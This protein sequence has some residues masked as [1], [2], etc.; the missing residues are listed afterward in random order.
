M[1][2]NSNGSS[3][4]GIMQINSSW[5]KPMGLDYQE[6]IKNPCYNV[7]TGAKILK[8]CVDKH[9]YTWEAIGCYNAVSPHVRVKYSWKVF[10]ELSRGHA[11]NNSTA[12][13]NSSSLPFYSSG[14]QWRRSID[15][16]PSRRFTV[17]S[18]NER[19]KKRCSPRLAKGR[20][21]WNL[22]KKIPVGRSSFFQYWYVL[23]FSLGLQ[24][25][26]SWRPLKLRYHTT[27][28]TKTH[29]RQPIP[30]DSTRTEVP[31][32]PSK[33]D[34]HV[35]ATTLAPKPLL[36]EQI[37]QEKPKSTRESSLKMASGVAR[38]GEPGIPTTI[39]TQAQSAG[40]GSTSE[41]LSFEKAQRKNKQRCLSLRS[42]NSRRKRR[43]QTGP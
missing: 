16:E 17:K 7:M 23:F 13:S 39:R 3:D 25:F 21:R 42:K 35:S 29:T 41:T 31:P 14:H 33:P 32:N 9:G 22:S 30:P 6:L 20:C 2:N 5:V 37:P 11:S 28:A 34:L 1:N 36:P 8:K 10:N 27:I 24:Q 15:H 12:S 26:T 18:K 40:K 19:V 4:L 38:D 43:I